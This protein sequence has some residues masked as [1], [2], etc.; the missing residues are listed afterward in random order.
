MYDWRDDHVS[1]PDY[2]ENVRMVGVKSAET[3]S[4]PHKSDTHSTFT[5]SH[6]EEYDPKNLHTNFVGCINFGSMTNNMEVRS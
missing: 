6:P 5:L 4:F 3:F 1:N 2:E